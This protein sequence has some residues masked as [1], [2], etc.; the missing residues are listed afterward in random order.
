MRQ[1]FEKWD[2]ERGAIR[3]RA[4]GWRRGQAVYSHGYSMMEDL[5]GK[6]SYMQVLAL[7]CTGR[8]PPRPVADW[9]EAIHI[10]LSWPDPR[11]WCNQIGALAGTARASVVA[12]TNAGVLAADSRTYGSRPIVEGMG[13]IQRALKLRETGHSVQ[14]IVARECDEHGGKPYIVGYARP[15][16]KGDERVIAMEPLTERLGLAGGPH[17]ALAHEVEKELNERFDEAMNINGFVSAVMSDLGFTPEEGYRIFA[18]VVMSGVTAC[19]KE[20]ERREALTFLPLHC[21]DIDYQGKPPRPLPPR[22]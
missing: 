6:T 15:L 17:L 19:H 5:V 3:S 8:L 1:D 2:K 12:G 18:M 14:D 7:N 4:G 21:A 10:C 13:F 16:T 11:I 20:A 9:L 22:G